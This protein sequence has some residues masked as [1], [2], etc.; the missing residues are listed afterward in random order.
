[1]DMTKH[2]VV[3]A[4]LGGSLLIAALALINVFKQGER[5]VT[6]LTTIRGVPYPLLQ[7]RTVI[8]ESL[9]HADIELA[10]PVLAKE[11]ELS[12][13]FIPRS[14]RHLAVGI[15]RDPFWLSYEPT[16]FYTST[17]ESTTPIS[18]TVNIPLTDKLQDADRSIDLMFFADTSPADI[19]SGSSAV[20]D[21]PTADTTNWELVS[22]SARVHPTRPDRAAIKEY[23]RSIVKRERP[24]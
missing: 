23:V 14:T 15:R 5:I 4:V 16:V 11:L 2:P 19:V 24:L 22:I 9:T 17:T 20:L 10:E 12:I 7:N 6:S 13:E 21:A 3:M 18:T 1:M 8:T